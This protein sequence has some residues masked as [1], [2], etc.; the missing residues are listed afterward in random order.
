MK[1]CPRCGG[2]GEILTPGWFH[3]EL[4]ELGDW[5]PYLDYATREEAI[6]KAVETR[7]ARNVRV[8]RNGA[9]VWRG[10]ASAAKE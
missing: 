6:H 9:T 4:F 2:R 1:S 5:S 10:V 7:W 3:V 8:T